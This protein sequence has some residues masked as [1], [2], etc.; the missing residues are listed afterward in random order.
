VKKFLFLLLPFLLQACAFF[1]PPP[2]E[3]LRLVPVSFSDLSGWSN[4]A[5]ADALPAFRKSCS[6]MMKKDAAAPM[7]KVG[8]VGDWQQACVALKN[9]SDGNAQSARAYFEA[10]FIPYAAKATK[11]GLFTGYYEAELHGSWQRGGKYQTP[12]WTRPEDMIS[13]DL[14]LFKPTLAGQKVTGKVDAQKLIPYDD[15]AAVAH[16]SLE[17]RAKPLLW[18]DDPVDAFFLEIQGSG[19]VLMEDGSLVRVGFVA[20]NG[21]SFVPVGRV[22]AEDGL[23]EKPVTM[24]KIRKWMTAHPDKAQ[25]VMN[26]NPSVVFFQQSNADGAVGAQGVVLTPERSMAVDPSFVPLGVPLWLDLENG[27][28]R[29]VVAQDTGGAIKGPVRGDFFWGTGKQAEQ[30]AGSMQSGGGYFLLVPKAVRL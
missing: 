24:Q 8:R 17:G 30:S 29:L 10:N 6:V 7:G 3:D 14:G 4:D 2:A 27:I 19:R 15:R 23:V 22:M 18:V 21:L 1:A 25:K 9:V 5:V 11:P 26:T 16:G 13:V 20:Q 28:R 12:L